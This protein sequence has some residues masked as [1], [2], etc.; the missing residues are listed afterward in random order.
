[1]RKKCPYSELFWAVFFSIRTEY[2]EIHRISPYSVRMRENVVQNNS[3]YKHFL[4]SIAYKHKNCVFL[5]KET[6]THWKFKG[7]LFNLF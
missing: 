1:M 7:K 5:W 2:G 6:S 3:E 4:R